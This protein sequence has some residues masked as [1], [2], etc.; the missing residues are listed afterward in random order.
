MTRCALALPGVRQRCFPT[1]PR[2]GLPKFLLSTEGAL[3]TTALRPCARAQEPGAALR[4]A[5]PCACL[6]AQAA[7]RRRCPFA[8]SP[9]N[10]LPAAEAV[11]VHSLHTRA[12]ATTHGCLKA[13]RIRPGC[14][15]GALVV[16]PVAHHPRLG[17]LANGAPGAVLDAVQQRV[18][19]ARLAAC[20]IMVVTWGCLYMFT[21]CVHL[22]VVHPTA[23]GRPALPRC[24]APMR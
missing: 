14:K 9:P 17:G 6:R 4:P 15:P 21:S 1:T 12:G 23:R 19:P 20:T 3:A 2:F 24:T 18:T 11:L 22:L 8:R 7:V 10:S 16:A 13:A 5:E